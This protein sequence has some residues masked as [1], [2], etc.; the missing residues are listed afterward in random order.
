MGAGQIRSIQQRLLGNTNT[1]QQILQLRFDPDM[2]AVLPDPEVIAL[3][4][5]IDF[6]GLATHPKIQKLMNNRKVQSISGVI[7]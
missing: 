1:V 7:N 6:Q 3:I 4:Q 5:R 2:Q